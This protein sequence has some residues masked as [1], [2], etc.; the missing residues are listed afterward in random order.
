MRVSL[1][2]MNMRLGEPD[3]NFGHAQ[4]LI[5]RAVR[6]KPDVICLPETWNVGFFPREGLPDLADR[7]G[8]ETRARLGA[9][10]KRFG[11]NL[12]AGSVADYRTERNAVT[13]TAFVL[14]RQGNVTA[15]YD[16]VHLFTNMGEEQSF[17]AGDQLCVFELDGVRCGLILCYDLRF[18]EWVRETALRGIE[19][20]FVPAQW[21]ESRSA[22][23][24]ILNAARAIENQ[25]FVVCTNSCGRAGKVH[26]GGHSALIDPWGRVLSEAGE[27]EEIVTGEIRPEETAAVRQ[28]IPVYR[29]RREE[30]Y[31]RVSE[32]RESGI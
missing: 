7:D 15:Q 10:A 9:L 24:R 25:I 1:I 27:E 19:V 13:N 30:L 4:E 14:D 8:E 17:A 20:L 23:W 16:K 2:Q 32:E 5:E 26:Y 18:T 12:V 29:D 11:V 28:E 22:H 31:R 6:E 3:Y 21:P